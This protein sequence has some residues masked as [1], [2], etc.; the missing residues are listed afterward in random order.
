MSTLLK[1]KAKAS[2]VVIQDFNDLSEKK[3]T[4]KQWVKCGSIVLHQNENNVLMNGKW[5]NSLQHHLDNGISAYKFCMFT[6]EPTYK[7]HN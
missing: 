2:S 6:I 5:L 3:K 4:S 1:K 7:N